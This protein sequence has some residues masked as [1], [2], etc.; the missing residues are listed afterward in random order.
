MSG[1][2]IAI[3]WGST[4][5]RAK[6]VVDGE[7]VERRANGL[8]IKN[9]SQ[10]EHGKVLAE[11]C[12]DWKQRHPDFAILMSGMVGSREGWVEVPYC[13]TPA[14]VGDLAVELVRLETE[15]M[16]EVCLVPGLRHDF[17]DGSSDVMRGEETEVYGLL[18]KAG[19]GELTVCAPG[20]HSKWVNCRGGRIVDFRTWLTG[21]AFEKL[22]Q[23]SLISGAGR[24]GSEELDDEAFVRGL[25][26]AGGAGGLLHHLFLGRTEMLTGR[27]AAQDLPALVSG[28][29]LGHE[30]REAGKFA[31]GPVQL[32]GDKRL[33]KLYGRAFDYLGL[34][35]TGWGDDLHLAG[36]SA[37][38]EL[39]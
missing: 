13:R 22:T 14:E 32:I 4:N 18:A 28:V 35:Y 37:L 12:G 17:P 6:L 1:G 9:V 11:L 34:P 38:Q 10:G 8:G 25:G 7:V 27:V 24:D 39:L 20:T 26:L 36:L 33:A 31:K 30:I 23:D 29:L 2:M 16:G 15:A 21:E 3:D 19:A 5:L